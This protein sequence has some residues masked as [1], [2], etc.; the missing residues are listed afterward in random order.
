MEKRFTYRVCLQLLRV[1]KPFNK[2]RYF[3]KLLIKSCDQFG[4]SQVL[5]RTESRLLK[6]FLQTDRPTELQTDKQ[7]YL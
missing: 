5:F 7:T 2:C 6:K 1:P 4:A 3:F